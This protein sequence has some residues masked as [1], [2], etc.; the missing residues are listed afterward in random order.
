MRFLRTD[1][2]TLKLISFSGSSM[3]EY[4]ILSHRWEGEKEEIKYR[5]LLKA[6]RRDPKQQYLKNAKPKSYAKIKNSCKVALRD[7]YKYIWID[8]CCI[9][10]S[11]TLELSESINSMFDW[12]H[13]SSMCYA[14][15]GDIEEPFSLAR[16]QWFTR[17]WTLQELI[18]PARVTFY[19]TQRRT[20]KPEDLAYCLLGIFSVNM[21][22][23]YGEGTRAFVRLQQEI[24]K[25]SD[26]QSILAFVRDGPEWPFEGQDSLLAESPLQFA[27]SCN[28]LPSAA[29]GSILMAPTSKTIETT[30]MLCP[31]R[32]RH[33]LDSK[34][35]HAPYWLGILHCTDRSGT[36][37]HPA[38]ILEAV[39]ESLSLF[40]RVYSYML[41]NVYPGGDCYVSVG[42]DEDGK[43]PSISVH[44]E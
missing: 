21:P 10:Q 11:D 32:L 12:Y 28:F 31:L 8:S 23:L 13:K 3:P 26:D 7:N 4:A 27:G 29:S 42:R 37:T 9:D 36:L 15:L 33:D 30:L 39:D 6:Q 40:R 43:T 38:I 19:D 34:P 22:L 18:A 17:G 41:V 16:S 44:Y 25:T 35:G 2:D 24:L 14:Y 5:D 1:T 20:T